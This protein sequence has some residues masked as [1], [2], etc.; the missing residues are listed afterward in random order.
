MV[1]RGNHF[2]TASL[3][4]L[5]LYINHRPFTYRPANSIPT[6]YIDSHVLTWRCGA[7]CLVSYIMNILCIAYNIVPYRGNSVTEKRHPSRHGGNVKRAVNRYII[8]GLWYQYTMNNEQY[9]VL[10]LNLIKS[11]NYLCLN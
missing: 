2:F 7:A 9:N 8:N 10:E 5:Y 3:F 4:I 1:M 6:K 11:L